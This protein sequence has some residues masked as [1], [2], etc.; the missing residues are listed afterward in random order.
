MVN[1]RVSLALRRC[2]LIA[3]ATLALASPVAAEPVLTTSVG[4]FGVGINNFGEEG[5]D[6]AGFFLAGRSQSSHATGTVSVNARAAVG[7]LGVDGLV[8]LNLLSEDNDIGDGDV[9]AFADFQ[10]TVTISSP[11]L[12]GTRGGI[13]FRILVDGGFSAAFP[14]PIHGRDMHARWN[15]AVI[16]TT[17]NQLIGGFAVGGDTLFY[18]GTTLTLQTGFSEDS[19]FLPF[20]YGTPFTLEGQMDLDMRSFAGPRQFSFISLTLLHS[21]DLNGIAGVEDSAGNPVTDY[22]I[23]AD[24]GADY[25]QPFVSAPVATVPEPASVTLLALGVAGFTILNRRRIVDPVRSNTRL[26]AVT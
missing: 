6:S 12:N 22:T 9:N 3:A 25:T 16:L 17:P 26:E 15:Y 4:G 1:T 5:T 24:S 2:F 7:S 18:D 13:S 20:I 19:D 8:E 23:S 10:D 14:R 21:A 11:T